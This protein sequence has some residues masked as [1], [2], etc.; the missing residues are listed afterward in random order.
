MPKKKEEQ[1]EMP[2]DKVVEK[3][4]KAAKKPALVKMTRDGR[5]AD[6]HPSEVDNF[7]SHGWLKA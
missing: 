2:V 5:S 6:V 3:K 4:P 7:K 1:I